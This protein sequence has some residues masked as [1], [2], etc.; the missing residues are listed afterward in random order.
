MLGAPKRKDKK[1]L[2]LI[3]EEEK[4]ISYRF[5]IVVVGENAKE[6]AESAVSSEMAEA[7]K[8]KGKQKT[9]QGQTGGVVPSAPSEDPKTGLLADREGSTQPPPPLVAPTKSL[10]R[11]EEQDKLVLYCPTGSSMKELTRLRIH[12]CVGWSDN[13]PLQRDTEVA[14]NTIVV[15]LHWQV[16]QVDASATDDVIREWYSRIAE[17]NHLPSNMRPYT[18]VM[19]YET[20]K[21]QEEKLTEFTTKQKVVADPRLNPDAC[22]DML[23]ESLQDLA[24]AAIL[25]LQ[26]MGRTSFLYKSESG[27][28]LMLAA[29]SSRCCAVS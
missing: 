25:R 26:N 5:T 15:L 4:S 2:T 24:E 3:P 7:Y 12:P 1:I 27:T 10:A 16:K 8:P 11:E 9:D 20:S 17:I 21:A 14:K 19:A 22:D 6:F 28:P 13:L 29:G 18:V 23:T